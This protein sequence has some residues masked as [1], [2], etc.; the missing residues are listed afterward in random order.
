MP[1][2]TS[3]AGMARSY[4]YVVMMQIGIIFACSTVRYDDYQLGVG[5]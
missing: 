5:W 1:A 2:S 3:V 4:V